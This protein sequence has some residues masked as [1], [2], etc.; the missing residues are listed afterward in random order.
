MLQF[1]DTALMVPDIM[2]TLDDSLLLG[3]NQTRD[4]FQHPDFPDRVLKIEKRAAPGRLRWYERPPKIEPSMTRELNGYADMM[5]RLGRHEPFVA[6][7]MG[8]ESTSQGTAILAEHAAYGA[9]RS[10]VLGDA[11]KKREASIFTR[12]ELATA[13]NLYV[14]ISDMLCDHR[15]FTHGLRNE[16][17]MLIE[18]DGELQ[19]RMFDFKTVVYR[20]LISPHYVPG[21]RLYEQ[22]R[23]IAEVLASFDRALIQS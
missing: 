18:K 4:V 2:I 11:I 3:R 23:K 13:R 15:I 8:L 21:A 19:L 5:I 14:N 12:D 16:N 22:R 9:S 17:L 20:Q 7:I 10:E 6:R 1:R